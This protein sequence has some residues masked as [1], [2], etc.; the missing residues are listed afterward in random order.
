MSLT[1]SVAGCVISDSRIKAQELD[2]IL[3]SY[4]EFIFIQLESQRL[5]YNNP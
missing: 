1:S 4:V 5:V 3:A 2:E